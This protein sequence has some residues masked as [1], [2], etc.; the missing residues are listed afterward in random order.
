[1]EMVQQ[2]EKR[3]LQGTDPND[4][5]SGGAEPVLPV[6][7]F[8]SFA[9]PTIGTD[10]CNIGGILTTLGMGLDILPRRV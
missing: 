4:P 6:E 7:G 1:M 10:G 5:N 3:L 8:W 9:S 2:M